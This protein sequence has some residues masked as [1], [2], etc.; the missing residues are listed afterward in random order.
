MY[1]TEP[2]HTR[3]DPAAWSLPLRFALRVAFIYA[4]LYL[5]STWLFLVPGA[6]IVGRGY[7][8]A[9]QGIDVWIA[10]HVLGIT[11][12]IDLHTLGTGSGDT[13]LDYLDIVWQATVALAGAAAWI[14]ID[15]KPTIDDA[16][17]HWLRVYV[18]YSLGAIMLGY[19]FAKVFFPGQFAH[20]TL[21]R[22]IEPFGH[23]SPMGLLWTFMGYSRAYTNFTGVVECLGGLLLFSP[24]TTTLGALVVAAAMGNVAMLNFSYDVPVKQYSTHLFLFAVLL[25]VPDLPRLVR[26]M[27]TNKPVEAAR[28]RP[29]FEIAWRRRAAVAL[30]VL[31]VGLILWQNAGSR[32]SS[33]RQ[34]PRPLAPRYG[35]YEVESFIV[36]GAPRPA[37]AMDSKRWRRVIVNEA[38]GISV[39]TMDD[40]TIRY[41]T[42]EDAARHTYELSTI[43]A[44]YD[45]TVLA[46]R[47]PG[48]GQLVLE[49]QYAGET[50]AVTLQKVALPSFLLNERGFHWISEYPYNR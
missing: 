39:Q 20:P 44:P 19:G 21:D 7:A 23:S 42:R 30:Q 12:P 31:I 35:I 41:R 2:P 40:A 32:S 15:R 49:G 43:F 46:Y 22:L 25:L 33:L 10:R 1:I 47:E 11:A 13:L 45:R 16:L 18:R 5:A 26:L 48:P 3:A 34:P 27:V 14:A 29:P 8:N 4:G 50:I 9:L 36:N 28:L 37:H 17:H 24:R 6:S 38:G